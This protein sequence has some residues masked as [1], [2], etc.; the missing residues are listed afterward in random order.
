MR[1]VPQLINSGRY[2]RPALGIDANEAVNQQLV[3]AL[4]VKGVVVLR[5]HPGSAAAQAG[6]RG[7][8][9]TPDGS[10]VPGDIIVAIEGRAVDSV[11]RLLSTLDDFKVGDVVSVEVQR[12]GARARLRVPLQAGT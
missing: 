9:I 5:V 12:A 7:V 4:E 8:T 10:V 6:L 2:V 11:A 3:R 1:V